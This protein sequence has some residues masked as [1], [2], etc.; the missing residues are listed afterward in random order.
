MGKRVRPNYITMR[1]DQLKVERDNPHNSASDSE[2]YNR[3]IQELDW[4]QQA[5]DADGNTISRNCFME[6]KSA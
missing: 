2:W 4:A 3:I 1:M 5:L 6:E